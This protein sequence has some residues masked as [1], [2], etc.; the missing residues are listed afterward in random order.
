VLSRLHDSQDRERKLREENEQLTEQVGSIDSALAM[1]LANGEEEQTGFRRAKFVRPKDEDMGID[2]QLYQGV[3]KAAALVQL[4]NTHLDARWKLD[5]AYLFRASGTMS[6]QSFAL[7]M[8]QSVI[9]PGKSGKIA[10]VVDKSA[11]EMADG[12]LADLALQI[13]GDDG[14]QRVKVAMKHTLI[15]PEETSR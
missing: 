8:D 12:Q 10:V 1:L 6:P 5:R 11:F 7:R 4:T 3:G 2:I 13:I 9:A 14:V 15:L